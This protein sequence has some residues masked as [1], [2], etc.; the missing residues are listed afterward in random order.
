MPLNGFQF[1]TIKN[2][3]CEWR[4]REREEESKYAN[5]YIIKKAG[6]ARMRPTEWWKRLSVPISI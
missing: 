6:E 5:N 3:L 4:D 2:Y 1:K